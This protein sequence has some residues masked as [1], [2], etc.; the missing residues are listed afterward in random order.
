MRRVDPA[1]SRYARHYD[2]IGQRRFG[3]YTAGQLLR[4]LNEAGSFPRT[5]LDL[6]CGTGAATVI[7]ARQ[8][9]S[10]TGLDLSPD[11]LDVAAESA[12]AAGVQVEWRTGDMT[13]FATDRTVDLCTCLYDAINYLADLTE[14]AGLAGSAFDALAPGGHLAFD[15]NTR[16]KLAEHWSE[17]TIIAANDDDRFLT[18][19]SWFEEERGVSPLIITG[20]ERGDDGTWS[21]FDEEHVETAFAI[22][23]V[24]NELASAG[25][26]Q[27][28]VLD[29]GE[30][31][32]ASGRDGT[33]ESFRVLFVARKP[34]PEAEF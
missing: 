23:D 6:A 9:L 24:R 11:M 29:W 3:E 17:M 20:F 34:M 30:G 22:D 31:N 7:F 25:F 16:R 2:Q 21:R 33:E 1:Y 28:D 15:I 32:A 5:V 10:A 4:I 27:I 14:I 13:S 18:Y 19:R 12:R 26:E 8:G